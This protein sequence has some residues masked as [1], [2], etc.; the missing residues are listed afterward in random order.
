MISS[1]SLCVDDNVD[2]ECIYTLH[3][4]YLGERKSSPPN[5][6]V[7]RV[8]CWQEE[9]T[10]IQDK[11]NTGWQIEKEETSS[12]GSVPAFAWREK[13]SGKTT[14]GTPDRDSNLDLPVI[15]SLVQHEGDALDHVATEAVQLISTLSVLSEM[16]GTGEPIKSQNQPSQISAYVHLTT[17]VLYNQKQADSFV[18]RCEEICNNP[19]MSLGMALNGSVLKTK[20]EQLAKLFDDNQQ[21]VF[22][23][24]WLGSF[25]TMF[26]NYSSARDLFGTSK[27]LVYLNPA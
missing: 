4:G 6:T 2:K 5:L 8:D 22:S 9:R 10:K 27:R 17:H 16:F 19:L 24:K 21:F 1:V 11:V 18:D 20:A 3:L 12:R 13:H 26:K 7:Y 25:K 23:E 15:G 14:L